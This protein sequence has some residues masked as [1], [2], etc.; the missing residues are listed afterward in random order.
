M[1]ILHKLQFH[2]MISEAD[3]GT[4]IINGS[5]GQ[6]PHP[7]CLHKKGGGAVLCLKHLQPASCFHSCCCSG[8]MKSHDITARIGRYFQEQKEKHSLP[9]VHADSH[10]S[11][12]CLLLP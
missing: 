10:A 12:K 11:Q 5:L 8:K 9:H 3:Q 1:D 4:R 7:L 6:L 2:P